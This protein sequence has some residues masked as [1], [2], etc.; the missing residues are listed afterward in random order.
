MQVANGIAGQTSK[1]ECSVTIHSASSSRYEYCF[2]NE[3]RTSISGVR[4]FEE[5]LLDDKNG[6]VPDKLTGQGKLAL[7]AMKK[8]C[9]EADANKRRRG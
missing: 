1:W 5:Y 2:S 9:K 7:V 4:K 6:Y 3:G 8:K